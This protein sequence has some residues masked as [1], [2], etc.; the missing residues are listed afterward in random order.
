MRCLDILLFQLCEQNINSHLVILQWK[1]VVQHEEAALPHSFSML[2]RLLFSAILYELP[3]NLI[4][5]YR[6]AEHS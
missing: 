6:D 1:P 3:V 5:G 4:K 2:G